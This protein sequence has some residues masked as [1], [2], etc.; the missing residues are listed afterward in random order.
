MLQS[1]LQQ[2]IRG[3]RRS[4]V[5][6]RMRKIYGSTPQQDNVL[7]PTKTIIVISIFALFG[8]AVLGLIYLLLRNF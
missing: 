1:N 7:T 5:K 2:V 3:R 8:L 6:R 4:R